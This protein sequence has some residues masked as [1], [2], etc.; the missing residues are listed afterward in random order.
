M[1]NYKISAR[2]AV[3]DALKIEYPCAFVLARL[4]SDGQELVAAVNLHMDLLADEKLALTV[5]YAFQDSIADALG[6]EMHDEVMVK[7]FVAEMK[8]LEEQTTRK[9]QR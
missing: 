2:C 4:E 8:E 7:H 9:A 6:V 5:N 3:E 1:N